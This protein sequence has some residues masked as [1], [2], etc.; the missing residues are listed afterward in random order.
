MIKVKEEFGIE[1]NTMQTSLLSGLLEVYKTNYRK[2][3]EENINVF[4]I[5]NIFHSYEENKTHLGILIDDSYQSD[6][7]GEQT[8]KLKKLVET[9]FENAEFK[10]IDHSFHQAKLH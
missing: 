4:E 3:Q 10:E 2:E 6:V 5:Q 7:E 8:L 9:I 1:Y